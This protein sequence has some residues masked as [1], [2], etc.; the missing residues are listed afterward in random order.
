MF[1]VFQ[2]HMILKF[3]RFGVL[4]APSFPAAGS[5][6]SLHPPSCIILKF[7]IEG[8]EIVFFTW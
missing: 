6:S 8:L 4:K 1:S 2:T 3:S 7:Q 5:P